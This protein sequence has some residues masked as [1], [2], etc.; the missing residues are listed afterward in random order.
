MSKMSENMYSGKEDEELY[1]REVF[2]YFHDEE[3]P[4]LSALLDEKKVEYGIS[5]DRQLSQII[6]VDR[7][8][9]GRILNG[10]VKRVDIL[11]IL[12]I[13]QFLGLPIEKLIQVYVSSMQPQSISELEAVRKKTFLIQNF[14]LSALKKSGFITSTQDYDAIEQRINTFFGLDSLFHFKQ[15]VGNIL[16]SRTKKRSE[17]KTREFWVR[18]AFFQF[19]KISNPN[20]FDP[21]LVER[22]ATKVRLHTRNEK[23]GFLA[24]ARALYSL[25]VTVIVQSYLSGIQVRG[26]TFAVNG[27]PCIVVTDYRKSYDTLWFSLMHELAHV[28]FDFEDIKAMK[29]H[30]SD[31]SQDLFVT[32]EQEETADYFA[33]QLLVPEEKLKYISPF[34]DTPTMVEDYAS[35]IG[36]HPALIY[37]FYCWDRSKQDTGVYARYAKFIPGTKQAARA[38]K[39]DPWK[40]SSLFEETEALRTQLQNL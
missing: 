40:K 29:Y 15:E 16:F 22:F 5:S 2:R 21:Q 31:Q 39:S 6:G 3:S 8:T 35:Q 32:T 10:E 30:L 27:K 36:V 23:T 4:D 25:G 14:D 24:V 33:R 9:L 18:C 38:I 28:L 20:E 11:S 7:S 37:G 1:L 13:N 19:E 17:D 34:I 12:K 26:A